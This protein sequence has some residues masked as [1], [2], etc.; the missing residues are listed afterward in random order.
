[1]VP[2]QGHLAHVWASEQLA[3]ILSRLVTE[4]ALPT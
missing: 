1:M 2:H 4:A 3:A